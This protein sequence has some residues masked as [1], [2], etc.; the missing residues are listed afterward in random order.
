MCTLFAEAHSIAEYINAMEELQKKSLRADLP[1]ADEMLLAIATKAVLASD[2]YPC[3]TDVWEEM[4]SQDR[5][6]SYRY[7]V[8]STLAMRNAFVP[9][10][11]AE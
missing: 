10:S 8:S 4:L 5:S 1:I 2:R 11:P 3:T 9:C 6:S 7:Q